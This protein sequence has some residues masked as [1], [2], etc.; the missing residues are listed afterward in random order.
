[1]LPGIAGSKDLFHV[2]APKMAESLDLLHPV[3]EVQLGLG[4]GRADLLLFI[5]EYPALMEDE[6]K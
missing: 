5:S 2:G 6:L 1:M 4:S 3:A